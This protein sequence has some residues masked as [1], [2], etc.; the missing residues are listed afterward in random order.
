MSKDL[1]T[2]TYMLPRFLSLATL[3]L[4]TGSMKG[5]RIIFQY[6]RHKLNHSNPISILEPPLIPYI[7]AFV[8][9]L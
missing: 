4:T 2:D 3:P 9:T 6:V 5:K 1:Q 8:L 7:C